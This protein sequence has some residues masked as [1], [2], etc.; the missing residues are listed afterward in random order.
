MCLSLRHPPSKYNKICLSTI[1]S[2]V[3][4][5]FSHLPVP[6]I[7]ST[8][9]LLCTRTEVQSTMIASFSNFV[10]LLAGVLNG[11]ET[12]G[13]VPKKISAPCFLF[14]RRGGMIHCQIIG[15]RCYSEDLPQGGMEVPCVYCF[16]GFKSDVNKLKKLLDPKPDQPATT[17]GSYLLLLS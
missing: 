8:E 12:V 2:H 1:S 10:F 16:N 17:K 7:V 11:S 6:L 3:L 13:H 9:L 14:L 4:S 15:S 5:I